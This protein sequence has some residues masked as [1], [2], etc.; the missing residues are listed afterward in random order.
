[1]S[2][3]SGPRWTIWF[4]GLFAVTLAMGHC[5]ASQAAEPPPATG[6]DQSVAEVRARLQD[7]E[8]PARESAADAK[9]LSAVIAIIDE[10]SKPGGDHALKHRA[11]RELARF[12]ESDEAIKILI[13]EILFEPPQVSTK[14][15]LATYTAASVLS[16]MGAKARSKVLRVGLNKPLSD[17]ELSMRGVVAVILDSDDQEWPFAKALTLR[18]M[19]HLREEVERQPAEGEAAEHKE[20]ILS[21]LKRLDALVSQPNFSRHQVTNF[22]GAVDDSGIKVELVLDSRFI[23][24]YDPLLVKVVITNTTDDKREIVSPD[25]VIQTLFFSVTGFYKEDEFEDLLDADQF[26]VTVPDRFPKMTLK[27]REQYVVYDRIFR[28]W[29]FADFV[30]PHS[31]NLKVRAGILLGDKRRVYSE[32]VNLGIS[33]RKKEDRRLI[34]DHVEIL[35]KYVLIVDDIYLSDQ[36]EIQQLETMQATLARDRGALPRLLRWRIPSYKF[37]YG[38]DKEKETAKKDLDQLRDTLSEPARE[39]LALSLAKFAFDQKDFATAKAELARL[40]QDSGPK[41]SLEFAIKMEEMK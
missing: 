31:T 35:R 25:Q 32:P 28:K 4:I 29:P 6:G 16:K 13:R 30:F 11:L 14:D 17:R 23:S 26:Q 15:P 19:R 41:R 1:M 34:E 5:L 7:K 12:P 8:R 38:T 21:N 3:N 40:T 27:P 39:M 37:K 22:T 9:L 24:E 33:L 10:E 18:R 2:C 36:K 20:A